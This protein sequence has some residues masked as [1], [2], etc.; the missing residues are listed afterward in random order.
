MNSLPKAHSWKKFWLFILV[1]ILALACGISTP[2]SRTVPQVVQTAVPVIT[3]LVSTPAPITLPAPITDEQSLLVSL[4]T[5]VNPSVVN[6]T[7]YAQQNGTMQR[8][9]QGSGFVYDNDRHI[10]TNAHVIQDAEQ[11][12]VTFSDGTITP[13]KLVGQ[14]SNS[15]LAILQ[16]DEIPGGVEPLSLGDMSQLAVGQTVIAIGNPFGLNGTLTRGVI[17]ALGRDIPDLTQQY[18][19]PQAIQTDAAINPGNS[20]GPLLNLE[21]QVIGI[22]AQIETGG[23]GRANTGVGF[24]IPVSILKRVLPDLASKGSTE[25][26]WLGV[27]GGSL[28]PTLVEAMK[29][30]VDKGAYLVEIISGGPAEKAGLR[31]ASQT[32]TVND[33]DVDVGGDVIIAIDGQPVNSFDDILVYIALQTYPGQEAKLTVIRNGKSQDVT[34]ILGTRPAELP[35]PTLP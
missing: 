26:A 16:V 11:I 27:R 20:G 22:N 19:I 3:K 9:A 32:V 30:P 35:T 24:A 12:E 14:D 18:S 28:N 34:L 8:L 10:A 7:T 29:L 31:G 13:A 4:Y 2:L 15:D 6:I 23:T 33:R 5:R 25:W 21:G 1:P 17:S